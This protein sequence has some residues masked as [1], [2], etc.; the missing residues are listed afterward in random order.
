MACSIRAR[1]ATGGDSVRLALQSASVSGDVLIIG[2]SSSHFTRV[3]RLFAEELAVPYRF[4]VVPDLRVTSS[5]S[6]ADNPALRV[7]ILT[8]EAGSWFGSLNI[9]RELARRAP[10]PRRVIWPEQLPT[11][12]LANAQE[13]VLQA[14]ASEVELIMS[15][16]D[17]AVPTPHLLKR[18]A[19]L[20]GSVAWL[21]QH[22]PQVLGALPERDLSF[23]EVTL[24]CLVEHLS[25]RGVLKT[26]AFKSLVEFQERFNAR[27]AALATRFAFDS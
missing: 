8:T 16:L 24:F 21:D 13:V 14:M 12:L 10:S 2:R 18:R 11:P 26:G 20:E 15:G 22:L 1:G 17:S 3:V 6:Y 4:Q 25:F 27:P 9:C 5:N 7:P 23:L 19:S